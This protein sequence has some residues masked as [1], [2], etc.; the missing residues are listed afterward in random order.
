MTNIKDKKPTSSP[1]TDDG[2]G[3]KES[4]PFKG[5]KLPLY[6]IELQDNI[7]LL[8]QIRKDPLGNIHL[9][10]FPPYTTIVEDYDNLLKL[11]YS[12]RKELKHQND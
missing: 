10:C 11:F 12:K 1:S 5:L 8:A 6:Y 9:W 4:N 7:E 3:K 2:G